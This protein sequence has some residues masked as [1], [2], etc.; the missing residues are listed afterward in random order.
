MGE[1]G[2]KY[3]KVRT[4]KYHSLEPATNKR[5]LRKKENNSAM[6]HAVDEIILQENAK[7]NLKDTTHEKIHDEVDEY[8]LYEIYRMSL[9]E[10]ERR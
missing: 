6:K 1:F 9:D 3:A 8:E 5:S 2:T 4:T 10:K 7:L